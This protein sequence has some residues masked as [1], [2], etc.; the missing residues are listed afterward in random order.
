M[1]MKNTHLE[2][3]EDAI[4][5]GRAATLQVLDF[6][7]EKNS[8]VS[9]K[10]D[11]APAIVFGH[12]PENGKRFVGTK[13]VFNKRKIKINHNHH[14][15]EVNHG[16]NE[17]VAS[18]LH[19]CFEC[20]P[21]RAGVWQG[22]FI[23]YGGTDTFTPNTITYK[24]DQEVD[25]SIVVAVHTSY[26]GEK[27]SEM[28]ANFT[29]KFDHWSLDKKVKYLSTDAQI[30]S[31]RRRIDYLIDIAGVVAN[32]ARFPS[33]KR[34]AEIKV[35]INRCIREQRD[36]SVKMCPILFSL[37]KLVA[38][39]KQLLMEGIVSAE[40]VSCYIGQDESTHEGYVM[41]NKYG[42][43]K[44]VNRRQFSYANFTLQKNWNK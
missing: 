37:Y 8:K 13:S 39:I 9:V 16:D 22:D 10:W 24:F 12:N 6:L 19:T 3:P 35:E 23:G 38:Y 26:S 15:I 11:G 4:L 1:G 36:I 20:L 33:D 32:L 27:M 44:L 7:K 41:T 40:S 42:T 25:H 14:E 21:D 43:Y 31:R 29:S 17:R 34:A 28:Q 2:H 30:T 5:Q 18:I